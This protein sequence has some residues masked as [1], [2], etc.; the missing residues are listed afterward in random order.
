M[1]TY[2][3]ILD[4][5]QAGTVT[6]RREG[7]WTV[8]DVQCAAA[9]GVKRVSVYGGGAEGYLGVL[10]PEDGALTLHRRFSRSAMRAFPAH[11]EY[12]GYAG[13]PCAAPEPPEKP[14]PPE[15]PTPPEEPAPPEEPTSPEEPV[16]EPPETPEPPPAPNKEEAP[17]ALEDV[18]WYA[19][20]DGALVCFDGE[21]N[22]IALPVG[23]ARIPEG[24][25][26]WQRTI[27]G[28]DYVVYRTKDGKLLR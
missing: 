5:A 3:L 20:P 18:Y 15:K 17:P 4:G 13:Q 8:F 22:L 28:R 16:P 2:P 24:P 12:A 10:A 21:H 11:I 23:D 19:S 26:G 25:G 9:E 14:A 6:V 7:G 1:E 27:E